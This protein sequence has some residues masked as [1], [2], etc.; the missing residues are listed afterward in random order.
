MGALAKQ[1]SDELHSVEEKAAKAQAEADAAGEVYAA[2][3]ADKKALGEA[4]Q[5]SAEEVRPLGD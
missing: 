3:Q 1:A 5:Q 4:L 2:Y